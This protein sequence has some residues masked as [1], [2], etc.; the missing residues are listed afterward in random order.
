MNNEEPY[1]VAWFHYRTQ[2]G[3]Q[4]EVKG[5]FIPP[6]CDPRIAHKLPWLALALAAP[7]IETGETSDA[8]TLY[9]VTREMREDLLPPEA[10]DADAA[11]LDAQWFGALRRCAIEHFCGEIAA[12]RLPSDEFLCIESQLPTYLHR[13]CDQQ[14]EEAGGLF[15]LI[16]HGKAHP[17]TRAICDNCAVPEQWERCANISHIQMHPITTV[18]SGLERYEPNGL[19]KKGESSHGQVPFVCRTGKQTPPCFEPTVIEAP[20]QEGRKIGFIVD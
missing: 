7:E 5:T 9:W 18:Q 2:Q 10:Q 15:C 3:P 14:C 6:G 8:S 19:C 20:R 12:G 17:T 16:E 13:L 1:P 11:A 4:Y